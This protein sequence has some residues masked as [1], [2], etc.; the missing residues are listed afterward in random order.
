MKKRNVMSTTVLATA[1]TAIVGGSAGIANAT[2]PCGD[3]G[4]CKVLTEIN[5]EDGDIGLHFLMDGHNL[6]YGALYN[7]KHRKIFNYF[8][9]REM[10]LQTS[11][12]LFQES[13][14]ELCDESLK[15]ED[16]DLVVTL[17]EFIDR[18]DAGEYH[19]FGITSDWEWQHGVTTMDYRLPAKPAELE[20]EFDE[21]DEGEL[22]ADISWEPGDDLG[23]CADYDELADMVAEGLLPQHPEDVEVASW[24]VVLEVDVEDGDP[25]GAMQ[26]VVRIPGDLEEYETEVPDDFLEVLPDNTPAKI[27]VGAIGVGDNATFA[28]EDEICINDTDPEGT[29]DEDE[30]AVLN[31]CGFEVEEEEEDD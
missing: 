5:A 25:L 11:T 15:E 30:D 23:E 18:F 3:F 24:E 13:A 7:P 29:Y 21:N 27:E 4:E 8:P 20:I 1:L 12:E 22:E 26:Y 31:G 6:I 28:E 16:D 17:E 9:R 10:R 14:E 19:V 2:E